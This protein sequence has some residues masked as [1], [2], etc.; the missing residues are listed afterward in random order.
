MYLQRAIQ[1]WDTNMSRSTPTYH[2][3]NV[4]KHYG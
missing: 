2:E 4:Q 1:I 3:R